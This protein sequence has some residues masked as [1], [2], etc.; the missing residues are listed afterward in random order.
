VDEV[1][2]S[3]NDYMPVWPD[4]IL[5][6]EQRLGTERSETYTIVFRTG[7]GIYSFKTD[8]I[9]LFQASQIGTEW[10]L[11]INTFGGVVSIEQ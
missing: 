10:N 4:P 7:D 2:L 9:D 6:E 5:S 3:G 8:D 11:N 1:V